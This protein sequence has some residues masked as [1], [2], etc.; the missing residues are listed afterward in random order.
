MA[1]V[2]DLPAL[3]FSVPEGLRPP[4]EV[5]FSVPG[6]V[7]GKG[8]PRSA[9]V[10]KDGKPILGFG[11]RPIMSV[12]TDEKTAAYENLIKLAAQRAM[13][14]RPPITVPVQV[15]VT[16]SIEPIPSWSDK[17][18]QGAIDCGS[19]KGKRE[20]PDKKPDLDNVIKAVLDGCN[21]V[22]FNDDVRVVSLFIEKRYA[23][24]EGLHVSVLVA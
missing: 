11:G 22:V 16:A 5:M 17:K 8:R 3:E 14:G 9:P 19:Y 13:D 20:A 23:A 7:R 2:F 18:R 4:K 21:G 12:H 24:I 10:M 1:D 6:K 15:L